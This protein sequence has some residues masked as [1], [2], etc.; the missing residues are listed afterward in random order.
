L[1]YC[2]I[3]SHCCKEIDT[4]FTH[5]SLFCWTRK[6]LVRTTDNLC[7]TSTSTDHSANIYMKNYTIWKILISIYSFSC[8]ELTRRD[9]FNTYEKKFF[10]KYFKNIHFL[11][12][13][14][15]IFLVSMKCTVSDFK[16]NRCHT[17]RNVAFTDQE[18]QHN[19]LHQIIRI[20]LLCFSLPLIIFLPNFLR[21][22]KTWWRFRFWLYPSHGWRKGLS[23]WIYGFT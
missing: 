16:K 2:T 18:V 21:A 12:E 6:C 5:C 4:T 14:V 11:Q 20:I 17:I 23:L 13:W 7:Q 8:P 9:M 22:A 3:F 10:H 19:F 1:T 15:I